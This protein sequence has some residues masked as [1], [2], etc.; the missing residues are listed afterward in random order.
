MM[1][2]EELETRERDQIKIIKTKDGLRGEG[3][4]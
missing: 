4:D 1:V 3:Q 2:G